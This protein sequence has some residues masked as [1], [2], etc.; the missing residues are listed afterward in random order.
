MDGV[1][2]NLIRK[3]SLGYQ[4]ATQRLTL[5]YASRAR[6]VSPMVKESTRDARVACTGDIW[7]VAI[8]GQQYDRT[9]SG[10]DSASHVFKASVA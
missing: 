10:Q 7:S 9:T 8:G 4:L 1:C 2:Q 3:T 5:L 6:H